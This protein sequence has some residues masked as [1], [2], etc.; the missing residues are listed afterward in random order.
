MAAVMALINAGYGKDNL[1]TQRTKRMNTST[2]VK[3]HFMKTVQWDNREEQEC[4]N[5]LQ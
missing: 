5:T 3:Q 4:G 1:M 2:I